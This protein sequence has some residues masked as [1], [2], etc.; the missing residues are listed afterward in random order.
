MIDHGGSPCKNRRHFVEP[1]VLT[2]HRVSLHKLGQAANVKTKL[3][4]FPIFDTHAKLNVAP[5]MGPSQGK[6]SLST[7]SGAMS[8]FGHVHF[9]VF[10]AVAQLQI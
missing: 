4:Q 2:R 3:K 10:G 9:S 5:K 1:S 7:K 6:T 8:V